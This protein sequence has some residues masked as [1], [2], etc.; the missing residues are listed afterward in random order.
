MSLPIQYAFEGTEVRVVMING[1]PWFFAV[2]VCSALG[3]KDTNKALQALD[4]DEKREHENYSG[5]GR[6]PFLI[7][8]A[9]LYS[10]ILRSH[11][12]EAKRF[13]RWVTHE[14]LPAI[15]KHG[16]YVMPE[17]QPQEPA[18]DA[19]LAAHVEADQIVSAG[20]AFRALFT[21]ARAMGMGRRLA[22]T[23][24]NLAA[25][26]ATGVDLV[27]ELGASGWLDGADLPS[28][29]RR[30]Y[31]LQQQIREHLTGHDWPQGFTGQQLIEALGLEDIKPVQTAVGQ[32]LQLL[33]YRRVR[34][35]PV[36]KGGR[37][38][39]LYVLQQRGLA[40]EVAA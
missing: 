33:G 34:S 26:R 31:D 9:G 13:K 7:N 10:L 16:A 2:D 27:A 11:K 4:S 25:F 8:E 18:Q 39:Y 22:A 6:K 12:P 23:R 28:S 21:S 32:C 36:E 19:P 38:P 1:E 24:A 40:L 15:R 29:T 5:S 3:L 30:Q 35:S 20:R 14:V 37:R 17:A